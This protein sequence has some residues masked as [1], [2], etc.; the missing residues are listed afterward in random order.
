MHIACCAHLCEHTQHVCRRIH[1]ALILQHHMWAMG[2]AAAVFE[3]T[4]AHACTPCRLE[5]VWDVLRQQMDELVPL[6]DGPGSVLAAYC[7][8]HSFLAGLQ[9]RVE[10]AQQRAR[11][12]EVCA[13]AMLHACI[14]W[15]L[16]KVWLWLP[17]EAMSLS[18]FFCCCSSLRVCV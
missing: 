7:E 1:G 4:H 18:R 6:L 2:C 12:E 5:E 8:V 15:G 16:S 10:Q 13:A 14:V 9:A 11:A 3:D 17:G